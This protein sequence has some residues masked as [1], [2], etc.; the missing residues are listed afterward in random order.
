M[1][2][3][4]WEC[5]SSYYQSN[6]NERLDE[7]YDFEWQ[8]TLEKKELNEKTYE[9]NIRASIKTLL[10]L[11]S[12]KSHQGARKGKVPKDIMKQVP[13]IGVVNYGRWNM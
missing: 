7:V 3:K 13:D 4:R 2:D 6:E 12:E 9:R 1:E 10:R 11:D 8:L 5:N